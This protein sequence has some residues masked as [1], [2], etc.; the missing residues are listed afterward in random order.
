ME[1]EPNKYNKDLPYKTNSAIC[2]AKETYRN[3]K[4]RIH[5]LLKY[6]RRRGAVAHGLPVNTKASGLDSHSKRIIPFPLSL[7]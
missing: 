2:F 3:D 1:L 5:N 6:C 7:L 4:N